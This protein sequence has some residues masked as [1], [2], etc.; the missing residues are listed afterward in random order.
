MTSNDWITVHNVLQCCCRR[1][2][3]T[4]ITVFAYDIL[5]QYNQEKVEA[6]DKLEK[7]KSSVSSLP[8]SMVSILFNLVLV[9]V[10]NGCYLGR[11]PIP[12]ITVCPAG[13]VSNVGAALLQS[14]PI[15]LPTH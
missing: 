1:Y 11:R 14:H 10:L 12:T 4:F 7:L 5:I 3:P 8:L 15:V 13:P 6:N 9:Y 2:L